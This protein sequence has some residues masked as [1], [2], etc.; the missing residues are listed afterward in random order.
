MEKELR[1]EI[2]AEHKKLRSYECM[3]DYYITG[4]C[5]NDN[6]IYI[7]IYIYPAKHQSKPQVYKS[8]I[9]PCGQI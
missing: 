6:N 2:L 4:L 7:Y 9:V 5:T 1:C 8:D 3:N